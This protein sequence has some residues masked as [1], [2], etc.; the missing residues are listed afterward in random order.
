[1]PDDNISERILASLMIVWS[2]SLVRDLTLAA[3]QHIF[4]YL[5]YNQIFVRTPQ[6]QHNQSKV[7]CIAKINV[8]SKAHH[9][10]VVLVK[11]RATLL[12]AVNE[13]LHHIDGG[14]ITASTESTWGLR[15]FSERL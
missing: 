13:K 3:L 10:H 4:L 2:F 15:G 1:M 9:I 14:L 8:S 6:Y 11:D 7:L 12:V 5:Y